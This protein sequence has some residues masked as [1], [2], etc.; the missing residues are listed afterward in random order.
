MQ[1]RSYSCRVCGACFWQ[2]PDEIHK[3]MGLCEDCVNKIKEGIQ[4]DDKDLTI[5]KMRNDL[6]KWRNRTLEAAF[7]C[8]EKCDTISI[9]KG[10]EKTRNCDECRIMRIREEAAK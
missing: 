2:F 8:C 4:M 10:T 1:M 5:Q 7:E 9:S 3:T 6:A